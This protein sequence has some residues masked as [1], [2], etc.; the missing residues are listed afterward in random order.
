MEKSN[1]TYR[2][3][4]PFGDPDKV[5]DDSYEID[6]LRALNNLTNNVHYIFDYTRDKLIYPDKLILFFGHKFPLTDQGYR[7]YEICV[8]P[9]DFGMLVKMNRKA[10]D[11]FYNLQQEQ[12]R[13]I[14]VTYDI[15]MKEIGGKY[16]LVNHHLTPLK[17]DDDGRIIQSI[18]QICLSCSQKP[19]NVFIR[20]THARKVFEYDSEL[21]RIR[22]NKHQKLTS[23]QISILEKF[24]QGYTEAEVA[25]QFGLSINTVKY[26][27]KDMFKKLGINNLT[28]LLQ[29][30]NGLKNI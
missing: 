30:V 12:K 7:F 22:E 1:L 19:G 3:P 6:L 10:S 5:A 4:L 14:S 27:K 20:L 11:F 24:A 16:I 9:D 28:Q 23:R 8:H 25:E 21:D 26:H 29:W 2:K 18:C 17:L 13:Y 15:R